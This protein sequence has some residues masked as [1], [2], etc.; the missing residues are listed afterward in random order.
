MKV[1]ERNQE[2]Y[3]DTSCSITRMRRVH[4]V[5]KCLDFIWGRGFASLFQKWYGNNKGELEKKKKD[6]KNCIDLKLSKLKIISVLF[7]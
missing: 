2:L 6:W 4:I 5:H 7:G 1:E 3:T